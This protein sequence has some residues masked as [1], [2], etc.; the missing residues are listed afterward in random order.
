MFKFKLYSKLK[1]LPLNIC[2]IYY[3]NVICIYNQTTRG[4]EGGD[5]LNGFTQLYHKLLRIYMFLFFI[6]MLL[7]SFS[8]FFQ[9]QLYFRFDISLAM[10]ER[11]GFFDQIS[12]LCAAFPA[13][14]ALYIDWLLYSNR[15]NGD[16]WCTLHHLVV[17][18]CDSYFRDPRLGGTQ[19]QQF[20]V[21]LGQLPLS[22]PSLVVSSI[23]ESLCSIGKDRKAIV[24]HNQT[25]QEEKGSLESK[26]EARHLLEY[27]KYIYW[28]SP[29]IRAKIV[30]LV[31][32]L[33]LFLGLIFAAFGECSV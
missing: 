6:R 7:T 26:R 28:M 12:F 14:F 21:K 5:Q 17:A 24:R 33:D 32:Y 10:V 11:Q 31:I 8:L 29:Q 2:R 20:W 22:R 25:V 13:L 30:A 15:H 4:E 23:E 16:I 1:S 9:N 18:N 3:N 19:R 27:Y